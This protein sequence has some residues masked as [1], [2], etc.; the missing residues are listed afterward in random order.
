MVSLSDRQLQLVMLS[1]RT[2]EPERRDVFLQRIDA[3]LRM[4]H[5]FD[6][7]D[8]IDVCG[9]ASCGLVHHCGDQNSWPLT[10]NRA[11]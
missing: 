6:D 1:A 8:V 7:D 2:I 10:V 11:T 9:L 3:M 5:R 4:R